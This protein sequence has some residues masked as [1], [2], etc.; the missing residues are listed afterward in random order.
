MT[1]L[2]LYGLTV[3]RPH[4]LD[5][6]QP[7]HVRQCQAVVAA[8]NQTEA[9]RAFN[10]SLHNLRGYGLTPSENGMGFA[11]S[12]PGTV[13]YAPLNKPRPQWV[14]ADG[15]SPQ[16]DTKAREETAM[17]RITGGIIG[18]I[19]QEAALKLEDSELE[20]IARWVRE[21]YEISFREKMAR[22]KARG[23]R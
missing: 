12:D 19:G 3:T 15:T 23:E 9:A 13:F 21:N 4:G 22:Q 20:A 16:D 7:D 18:A 17:N 1:K 8:P 14:R 5:L 6:D 10:V 11:F 2:K